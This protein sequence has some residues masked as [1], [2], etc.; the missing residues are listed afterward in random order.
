VKTLKLAA[1]FLILCLILAAVPVMAGNQV[2]TG[3]GYGPYQTGEGGEFTLEALNTV[4]GDMLW[5]LENGYVGGVT[6]NVLGSVNTF[7]TFCLEHNEYIYTGKI[8]DVTISN[9]AKNGGVGGASNYEDPISVGTAWL[10]R[11]F[12]TG[13]LAGYDYT[14]PGRSTWDGNL[15]PSAGLL[16]NAIWMLEDEINW[17][18]NNQ[19]IK[20]MLEAGWSKDTLKANDVGAYGV[21]V[22]NMYNTQYGR[23]QDQLV[24]TTQVPEPT[25]L[26]L[27]GIS[28]FGVVIGAKRLYKAQ[29]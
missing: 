19:F 8:Y 27:L 15:A 10:Y 26:L 28:L 4:S 21:E 3:S 17:D 7:Q 24:L 18:A 1:S 6:K 20:S 5:V 16:Q 29:V 9:S 22:L 25:A 14:N 23:C 2:K 13:S 12:A 11:A